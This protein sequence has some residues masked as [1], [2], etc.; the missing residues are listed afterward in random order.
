VTVYADET[1]GSAA[2]WWAAVVGDRIY[3]PESG[4]IGS[5]GARAAHVSE[6]ERLAKDGVSVQYFAWPD[7]GKVA[8]AP[9]LPLSDVARSRGERDVRMAGEAFARA[10]VAGRGLSLKRVRALSADL[11]PA[12]LAL[13]AGLIDAVA[14]L[15]DA[16][17]YAVSIASITDEGDMIMS[18]QEHGGEGQETPEEPKNEET[19]PDSERPAYCDKCGAKLTSEEPAP[20]DEDETPESAAAPEPDDDDD[21]EPV[22]PKSDARS[23]ASVVGCHNASRAKVEATAIRYAVVAREVVK[24]TGAKTLDEAVGRLYSLRDDAAEV[25]RIRAEIAAVKERETVRERMDLLRTLASLNLPGYTRGDLFVDHE[26]NGARVAEPSAVYAE[27]KLA[28]LRGLVN[29]KSASAKS[30]AFVVSPFEPSHD[31]AK[32]ASDAA[33]VDAEA[34]SAD[35]DDI[36]S[37]STASRDQIAKTRA[38]L[39]KQQAAEKRNGK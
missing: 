32:A 5:V 2:Y 1:I 34:T 14:S 9:E 33:E 3:A 20:K 7:M 6:A 22:P 10:V 18:D 30:A 23:L 31:A 13:E 25:A 17:A 4:W 28:T 27:M 19:P 35:V 29:A 21:E 16:V 37:R 8:F 39:L 38:A 24:I 12:P 11:L 15:E 36:A 26:H